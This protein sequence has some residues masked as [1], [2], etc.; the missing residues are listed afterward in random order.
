MFTLLNSNSLASPKIPGTQYCLFVEMILWIGEKNNMLVS[1]FR[2]ISDMCV[3]Q[4]SDLDVNGRFVPS[5]QV[6]AD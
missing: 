1:Q 6:Q 2:K 3:I 5:S 4:I